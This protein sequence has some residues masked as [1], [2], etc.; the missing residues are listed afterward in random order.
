M[1]TPL[2]AGD[3]RRATSRRREFGL[4]IGQHAPGGKARASCNEREKSSAVEP[5]PRSCIAGVEVGLGVQGLRRRRG[6]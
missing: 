5:T 3:Y 2:D 6:T 4:V 1:C